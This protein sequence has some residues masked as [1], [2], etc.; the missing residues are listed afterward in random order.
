MNKEQ[1]TGWKTELAKAGKWIVYFALGLLGLRYVKQGVE[2]VS[3]EI[4]RYGVVYSAQT[5]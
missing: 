5:A 3:R 2:W 4:A 1:D